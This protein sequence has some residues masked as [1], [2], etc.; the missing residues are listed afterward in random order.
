[1]K[2]SCRPVSIPA[3]FKFMHASTGPAWTASRSVRRNASGLEIAGQKNFLSA[4][5]HPGGAEVKTINVTGVAFDFTY[6]ALLTQADLKPVSRW[7]AVFG[8]KE[9]HLLS[10]LGLHQVL[11]LYLQ[12]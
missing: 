11:M 7:E 3:F 8:E 1:M 10:L 5:E 12:T 9:R 4:N 2:K 6:L